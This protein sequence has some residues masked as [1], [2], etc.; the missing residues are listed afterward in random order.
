[1]RALTRISHQTV[2]PETMAPKVRRTS[3][4]TATKAAVERACVSGQVAG[5]VRRA[6]SRTN[7]SSI[8]GLVSGEST[9]IA[10]EERERQADA[11]PRA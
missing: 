6:T 11:R 9:R 5:V 8:A 3:A 1:M 4:S 10:A 2:M 7:A